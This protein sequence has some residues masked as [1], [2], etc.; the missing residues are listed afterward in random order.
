MFDM[1]PQLMDQLIHRELKQQKA[2]EEFMPKPEQPAPSPR[3]MD[4]KWSMLL[5]GAADAASTYKF[6]KDGSMREGNPAFAYFNKRP[7]TVLPTAAGVGLGYHFLHKFLKSK[8]P[9]VADTAAG[10]LGGYQ[11]A[12][13]GNNMEQSNSNSFSGAANDLR[14]GKNVRK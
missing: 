14:I 3:P 6:L 12:L 7:W 5:G 9:K 1:N 13:G 11:M 8:A 2:I 4:P 10:L